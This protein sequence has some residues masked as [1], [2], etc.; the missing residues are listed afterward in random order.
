MTTNTTAGTRQTPSAAAEREL[1]GAALSWKDELALLY[2]PDMAPAQPQTH[3]APGAA[4]SWKDEL[5][6]LQSDPP[7]GGATLD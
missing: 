1:A 3:A 6:L 7:R 4:L 5:A 2:P